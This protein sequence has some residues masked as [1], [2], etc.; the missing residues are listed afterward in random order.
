MSG[1]SLAVARV[2]WTHRGGRM[3]AP[4]VRL[5]GQYIS[6]ALR[7]GRGR[8]HRRADRFNI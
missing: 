4:G 7:R 6:G 1:S 3:S 5:W 2:K 8:T